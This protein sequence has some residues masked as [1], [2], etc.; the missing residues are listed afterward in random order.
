LRHGGRYRCVG[1]GD[2]IVIRDPD[3]LYA[4]Q[5]DRCDDVDVAWEL[6]EALPVIEDPNRLIERE[7]RW[8]D[9]LGGSTRA[10]PKRRRGSRVDDDG[11]ALVAACR[12]LLGAMDEW[13]DPRGYPDSLALCV[14]DSIWSVGV[15]YGGVDHVIQ[16]YRGA[17]GERADHDGAS[18]LVGWIASVGGA[19][20][21][22][23]EVHNHQR[24]F[25]STEA[26]LKAEVVAE[27]AAMLA[28]KQIETIADFR[29]IA[30]AIGGPVEAAWLALPSQ[31]SGITWRYMCILAGLPDVK[32]DRMIRRFVANALRLDD[33][34]TYRAH[35]A[36]LHVA[37]EL[38]VSARRLDHRIWQYQ[39]G[40][41]L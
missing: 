26:P 36:V 24:S 39:S 14:I 27:A 18:D 8:Q 23:S 30:H 13:V 16:A 20:G 7:S 38:G 31:S 19:E 15:Q 32:P 33:V 41:P 40:R 37:G 35:Q 29:A 10:A 22:A 1:C 17:R 3:A 9:E 5:C 25:A 11:N 28:D 2:L 12:E 34:T 4:P 21:F 6:V